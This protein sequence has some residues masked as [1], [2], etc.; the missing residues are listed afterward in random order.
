MFTSNIIKI[1]PEP[2][3][4]IL[5]INIL[6]LKLPVADPSDRRCA[7]SKRIRIEIAGRFLGE[8]DETFEDNILTFIRKLFTKQDIQ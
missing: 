5:N 8:S 4:N 6:E 3:F 1:E 7:L 2:F